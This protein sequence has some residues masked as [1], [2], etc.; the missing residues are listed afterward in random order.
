VGG[1]PSLPRIDLQGQI[2]LGTVVEQLVKPQVKFSKATHSL[3]LCEISRR[4]QYD[5]DGVI[6]QLDVPGGVQID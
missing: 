5:D 3:L 2:A 4:P 6:L 1:S